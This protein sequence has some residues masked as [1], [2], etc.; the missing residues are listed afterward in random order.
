MTKFKFQIASDIVR[1]GLGVELLD[2]EN[3]VVAEVF[4]C[5]RDHTIVVNTFGNDILIQAIRQLL[6]CASVRLDPFEDGTS[7]DQAR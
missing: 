4:R 5:D 2:A 7:L 1:D 3:N 6:E